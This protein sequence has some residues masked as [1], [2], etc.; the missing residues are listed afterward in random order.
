MDPRSVSD[1]CLPIKPQY[2][3]FHPACLV[4]DLEGLRKPVG[5]KGDYQEIRLSNKDWEELVDV[6]RVQQAILKL[7]QEAGCNPNSGLRELLR[8]A[9]GDY[10]RLLTRL[11]RCSGNL[12]L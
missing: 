4:P 2:S 9:L 5:S 11:M 6:A 10:Q 8:M 12:C 1:G 7:A 3:F